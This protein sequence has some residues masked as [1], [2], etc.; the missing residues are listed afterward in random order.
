MKNLN[1]V[2]ELVKN[3]FQSI[4]KMIEVEFRDKLNFEESEIKKIVISTIKVALKFLKINEKN[5]YLSIYFTNNNDI[6]KLNFKYRK[7]NK[8]TNVLSF[9]QD[10]KISLSNNKDIVMLGDIVI[11]LE[12]INFE[13][14]KL[15]KEFKDHLKHICVH[16]LLHLIGYDHNKEEDAKIM[17]DKEILILAKLS[18]PSPY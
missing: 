5:Y 9:I 10:Q 2:R 6:R 4:K 11:S 3:T 17:E 1:E 14:K 15:G 18:V 12:K 8:S 16:G 7:K 13:A